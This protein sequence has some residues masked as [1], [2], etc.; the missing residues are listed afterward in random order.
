MALGR[1]QAFKR[2]GEDGDRTAS[3]LIVWS[4]FF[5]VIGNGFSGHNL[6]I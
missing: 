5:D 4:V 6:P 2:V 1:F 3:P